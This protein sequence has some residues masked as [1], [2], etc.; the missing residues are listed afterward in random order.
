[1]KWF[2]DIDIPNPPRHVHHRDPLLLVGSCFTENIGKMLGDL[3]F[4]A[5]YNPTGILFDP[6]SVCRHLHDFVTRREYTTDDLTQHN[7]VY[8]SWNHH[9]KFSNVDANVTVQ[10]INEAVKVGSDALRHARWVI[11]TLGSSFAYRL[12]ETSKRVANCHK[13][14]QT[15]FAKEMM[16]TDETF[17]CLQS[18]FN[19]IR[20][21]NPLVEFILT[22]SPVRH[23]RD[24]LA[25]NNRSKARLVEAVHRLVD[26]S[27]FVHYFPAY[28]LV[29]D[30]LRD[31]R[32]YDVD[33]VHPNYAAT[34]FV[35]EKFCATWLD[36]ET[37]ALVADIKPIS[38]AYNHKP[39]HPDTEAHKQFMQRQL[40]KIKALSQRMPWCDWSKEL[41][42]F[43]S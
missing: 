24:G 1:M 7:S 2:L 26:T 31:Y 38:T 5:T 21:V 40:E 22:V 15:A 27:D 4:D 37:N 19:A 8:H 32:F 20:A 11:V 10:Q 35:F 43:S 33:L 36:A 17:E 28:E 14:P 12:N 13:V 9:S 25:Q 39:Q 34:Q 42:Y 6:D 16:T 41:R 3:K 29:I 30:V 23:S 18:A